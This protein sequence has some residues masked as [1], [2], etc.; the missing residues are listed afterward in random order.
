MSLKPRFPTSFVIIV[1]FTVITLAILYCCV[2]FYTRTHDRT[3]FC[4]DFVENAWENSFLNSDSFFS[5]IV[6]FK[7][8]MKIVA[9]AHLFTTF[10]L[11]FVSLFFSLSDPFFRNHLPGFFLCEHIQCYK[12]GVHNVHVGVCESRIHEHILHNKC[13]WRVDGSSAA[14]DYR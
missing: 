10:F 7:H 12:M 6:R 5:A 2:Y 1:C 9:M 8:L 4:A 11:L 14:R 13:F 3:L